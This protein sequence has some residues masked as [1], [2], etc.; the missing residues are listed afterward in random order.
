VYCLAPYIGLTVTVDGGGFATVGDGAAPAT[1]TIARAEGNPLTSA[2][3]TAV[4][5]LVR[6]HGELFQ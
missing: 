3:A 6:G 2:Q 4:L 1:F 5:D